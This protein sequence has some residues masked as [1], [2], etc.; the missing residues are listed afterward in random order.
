MS[1]CSRRHV[2]RDPDYVL[3]VLAGGDDVV[4]VLASA[5]V[6]LTG[7]SDKGCYCLDNLRDT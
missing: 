7:R 1:R 3:V 2:S 6:I 4:I 5:K